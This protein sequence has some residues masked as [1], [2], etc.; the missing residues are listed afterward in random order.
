MRYLALL[1]LVAALLATSCTPATAP[2][3]PT[4]AALSVV[5]EPQQP[6]VP[7]AEPEPPA[8]YIP[9]RLKVGPNVPSAVTDQW[10]ELAAQYPAVALRIKRIEARHAGKRWAVSYEQA[11]VYVNV[12]LGTYAVNFELTRQFA[13]RAYDWLRRNYPAH[14]RRFTREQFTAQLTS[15]VR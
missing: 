14:A 4:L 9:P 2:G 1:I 7:P 13:R 15:G 11:V 12:D 6:H 5:S 8:R 10:Y 3:L